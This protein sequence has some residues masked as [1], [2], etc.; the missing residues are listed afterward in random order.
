M[1]SVASKI[2][3]TRLFISRTVEHKTLSEALAACGGVFHGAFALLYAPQHCFLAKVNS[4]GKFENGNGKIIDVEKEAVFEAR[5]FNQDAELRWLNKEN[6]AGGAVVLCEDQTKKFFG[7]EPKA[8]DKIYARV[9]PPQTYFLWGESIGPSNNGWTKFAEARIGS[10]LV[11]VAGIAANQ[12]QRAQFTAVEYLGEYEDGN[13]AVT[14]ER[15]TR[16]QAVATKQ[17]A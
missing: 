8:A 15:L 1:A 2:V 9:E 10:F 13:V 14:E 11:P 7:V 16:I 4:S 12:K 6:G 3:E 5:L 17:E